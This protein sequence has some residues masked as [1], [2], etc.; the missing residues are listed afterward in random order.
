MQNYDLLVE[1]IAKSAGLEKEEIERKIE[2]K[3]AK[4][5]GLISKE[6][7]A[8]IIAAELGI[9]FENVDLK[10][11]ELMPGMKKVN[12]VGKVVNLFPVREFER[13]GKT[14]KVV[15]FFVGDESGNVRVVLWDTNHISL[16]ESGEIKEGDVVEIKNGS[17]RDHEVHLSGFSD[18]KKSDRVLEDVKTEQG[19]T[20]KVIEELKQGERVKIR[21][22]VVQMFNPRFFYVCPDC[23]KKAIQDADGFTCKEHGKVNA[24]ERALINFVVDDGTETIRI[25]LFSDQ[26]EKLVNIEDLKDGEKLAVFREDMLGSELW[27]KGTVK[28]NQLFNN[29]EINVSD[30]KKV[31]VE[32]LIKELESN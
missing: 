24:N 9:N 5:S 28:K 8:Q 3:K 11:K 10:I 15:N 2:A 31:D 12:F 22:S 19:A 14:N 4:L 27:I 17:M 21:G 29:L 16:I 6:G 7:A 13:K 30:V 20:E 26:L 1:R 23:G 18:I 32:A 25:V